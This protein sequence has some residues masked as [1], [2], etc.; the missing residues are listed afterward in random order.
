MTERQNEPKALLSACRSLFGSSL[1][2]SRKDSLSQDRLAQVGMARRFVD[3]ALL[4]LHGEEAAVL[5]ATL[6]SCNSI[7]ANVADRL[8]NSLT[9]G[10]ERARAAGSLSSHLDPAG[11]AGFSG[12]TDAIE[13]PDLMGFL[14]LQRKTGVLHVDLETERLSFEF[15]EGEVVCASSDNSPVGCRLGE[16]L[17]AQG[18]VDKERLGAFL[19]DHSASTG[20]L[21]AA[22]VSEALITEEQLRG[23]LEVQVQQIFHRLL[24][25]GRATFRFQRCEAEELDR[26]MRMNVMQ[27]LLE[28]ARVNDEAT[29]D[30]A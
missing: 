17:I 23:A 4:S 28:S 27:L 21:G 7:A 25:A 15:V 20:K 14:Q 18:G 24:G 10:A 11:E 1:H 16:I 29:Q 12:S 19:I 9:E 8:L 22:L 2:L 6:V 5:A 3:L 13:L 26:G 30:A